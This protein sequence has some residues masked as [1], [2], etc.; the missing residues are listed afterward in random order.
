MGIVHVNLA[1]PLAAA[2]KD[3]QWGRGYDTEFF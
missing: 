1:D 2:R 3:S